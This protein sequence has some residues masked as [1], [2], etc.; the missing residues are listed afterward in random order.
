MV[1]NKNHLVVIFVMDLTTDDLEN[2]CLA[3]PVTRAGTRWVLVWVVCQDCI[4]F[5]VKNNNKC[6]E[7]RDKLRSMLDL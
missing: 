3:R 2:G 1:R 4:M 5:S 7:V 6:Y